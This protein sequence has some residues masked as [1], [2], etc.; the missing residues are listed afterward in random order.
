MIP[1]YI[2]HVY[3]NSYMQN[4]DVYT[5][6]DYIER[7][8]LNETV[9]T[10]IIDFIYAFCNNIT[11][12]NIQIISYNDFC[13]KFWKKNEII[14]KDWYYIFKVSYFE[15]VWMEW[16]IEEYQEQIYD[17]YVNKYISKS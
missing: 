11:G 9:I 16:N 14:D 1:Y 17:A 7:N 4:N 3:L 13:D 12:N 2:Q 8:K 10:A 15:N 5:K 6:C